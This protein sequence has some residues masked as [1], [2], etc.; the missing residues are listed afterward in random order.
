MQEVRDQ[1]GVVGRSLR[2]LVLTVGLGEME[3]NSRS[4]TRG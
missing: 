1:K 4:K 3:G 2:R